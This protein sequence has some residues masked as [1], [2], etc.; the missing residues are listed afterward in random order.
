MKFKNHLLKSL[1]LISIVFIGISCNSGNNSTQYNKY[2][3]GLEKLEYNNPDLTVD[4]D[5]GFKAV[6][7]PVDFDG[8]GDYDLLISESGSYTESG[9]FY[10]ENITGNVDMPVFKFGM[11]VSTERFRLGY[12]GSLFEI[13]DVDGHI[14]VLTPDRVG[15]KLLI[16]KNIPQNVFWD[17]NE[18]T[19]PAK[20]Y[21]YLHNFKYTQWKMIDF[22]G[23]GLQ[24]PGLFCPI[25]KTTG[26]ARNR[27]R[28]KR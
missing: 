27:F 15:E 11:Q 20:G 28:N 12:D 14:H 6:P 3:Y 16:Y 25:F 23:D 22:D 5:A 26:I 17:Q 21:E 1:L 10:F 18:I 4:L 7:L 24:G 2:L 9:V 8:D 13:S 19:L